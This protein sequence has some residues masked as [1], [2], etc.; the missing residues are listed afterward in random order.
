ML[1][2]DTTHSTAILFATSQ[3]GGGDVL[4][5]SSPLTSPTFAAGAGEV[6]I[7]DPAVGSVVNYSTA[8][9]QSVTSATG[10]VVLASDDS[11]R[12]YWHHWDPLS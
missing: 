4:R 1:V 8:S 5:K 3:D 10:L 2:I 7:D 9:K 11:D 12:T 6:A